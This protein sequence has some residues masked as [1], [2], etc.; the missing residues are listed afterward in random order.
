M[1]VLGNTEIENQEKRKCM[2]QFMPFDEEEKKSKKK[3][4]GVSCDVKNCTYH[5]G[6]SYCTAEQIAVG[7]SYATSCTDT[8]CAT[9]R[10]KSF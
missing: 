7:P 10:P 5:D 4:K 2:N 3:N 8:V 1:F 9:F 6:E